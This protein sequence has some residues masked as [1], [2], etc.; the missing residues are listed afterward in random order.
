M[1]TIVRI[2]LNHPLP[3]APHKIRE[4][5]T[6]RGSSHKKGGK[7]TIHM[8][9]AFAARQRRARPSQSGGQVQ[10][11]IAIPALLD[12]LAIKGALVT[13]DAM[14]CQRDIAFA[15]VVDKDLC[16]CL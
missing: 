15:Q 7:A 2:I 5:Q 13:I 9:S 3:L 1:T 16:R 11:D 14:G 10:R 8:V 4:I 12:T 6:L